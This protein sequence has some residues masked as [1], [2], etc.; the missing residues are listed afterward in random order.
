MKKHI[1]YNLAFHP[2]PQTKLNLNG[3]VELSFPLLV[4]I[5]VLSTA[6]LA[7]KDNQKINHKVK[8]EY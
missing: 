5:V 1:N 4:A 7:W 3:Q 2:S 6:Y 8:E